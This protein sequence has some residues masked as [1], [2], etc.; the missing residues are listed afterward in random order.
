MAHPVFDTNDQD[1]CAS[2]EILDFRLEFDNLEKKIDLPTGKVG[3]KFLSSL[4]LSNWSLI[5]G[6]AKDS[7]RRFLTRRETRRNS[8]ETRVKTMQRSQFLFNCKRG[9]R[10]TTILRRGRVE[11]AICAERLNFIHVVRLRSRKTGSSPFDYSWEFR[12]FR[13]PLLSLSLSPLSPL[14]LI[15]YT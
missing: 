8:F 11:S 14:F 10:M 5:R 9:S 15:H 12:G 7:S 13:S 3:F 4:N 1:V 6:K 2:V